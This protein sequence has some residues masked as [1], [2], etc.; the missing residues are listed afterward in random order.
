MTNKN[1][2]YFLCSSL[3]LAWVACGKIDSFFCSNIN[4]PTFECGK[5]I[6]REAGGYYSQFNSDGKN[7]ILVANPKI[8]KNLTKLLSS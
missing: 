8:H 6:I 4:Q 7:G 2:R 5:L 3:S 1:F